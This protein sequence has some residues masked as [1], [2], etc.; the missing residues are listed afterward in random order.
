LPGV[1]GTALEP[2]AAT[3]GAVL[4][5][6]GVGTAEGVAARRAQTAAIPTTEEL[7]TQG[8]N[9]YRQHGGTPVT[10]N[11]QFRDAIQTDTG[12]LAIDRAWAGAEANRDAALM[13]E[14]RSLQTPNPPAQVS[15]NAADAIRRAFMTLGR[16]ALRGENAD[17]YIARGR[18][19]RGTDVDSVLAQVPEI[20]EGRR[21]WS[22]AERS[23][24]IDDAMEAARRSWSTPAGYGDRAQAI[25]REFG[26]LV[27]GPEFERFAPAEQR[28]LESVANGTFTSRRLQELGKLSPLKSN[29]TRVL[30]LLGTGAGS[31]AGLGTVAVPALGIAAGAELAR[32]GAGLA[33]ARAVNRASQLVRSGGA[34]LQRPSIAGPAIRQAITAGILTDRNRP[35]DDSYAA[36]INALATP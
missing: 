24:V 3:A 33:S 19:G 1:K 25:Q 23:Q 15:A 2:W 7:F 34:T 6:A 18:F 13:A 16:S 12:H 32:Q 11:Q 30:G 28:A 35:L 20:Q 5:G 9:E 22:M 10:L 21:L 17:P 26:R 27:R 8:G 31:A 36:R 29:L 14:L 4:G